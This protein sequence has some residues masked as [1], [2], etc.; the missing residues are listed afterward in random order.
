MRGLSGLRKP[1]ESKYGLPPG[2]TLA[3]SESQRRP[4]HLFFHVRTASSNGSPCRL[5]DVTY[6]TNAFAFSSLLDNSSDK[7]FAWEP[8]SSSSFSISNLYSE[9]IR[10]KIIN[11]WHSVAKEKENWLHEMEHPSIIL[12]FF[13]I[14]LREHHAVPGHVSLQTTRWHLSCRNRSNTAHWK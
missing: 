11:R 13:Q 8:H 9:F 4:S 14:D 10:F 6:L 7:L 1:P 2:V 12:L 3:R 5:Q